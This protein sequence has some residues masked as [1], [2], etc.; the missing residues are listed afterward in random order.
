MS[1]LNLQSFHVL[2]QQEHESHL[3]ITVENRLKPQACPHCGFTQLYSH[4]KTEQVYLKKV[5]LT[6]FP[7]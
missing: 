3:E 5:N 1:L 7:I 4:D 2:S 6:K